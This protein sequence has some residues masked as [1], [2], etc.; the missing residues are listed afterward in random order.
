MAPRTRYFLV[1]S[2]LVIVIGL[3]TGLV[4]YYGGVTGRAAWRSDLAYVPSMAR[5]VGYADLSDIIG[6]PFHQH[7][8]RLL[9][10]G[11]DKTT[12]EHETGIDV[13]RDIDS[14]LVALGGDTAT[15]LGPL[16][17]VR[18]RFDQA[19]IEGTATA[20]GALAETYRDVRMLVAPADVNAGGRLTGVPT[21]AFLKS[22]LIALGSREAIRQALD[23]EASGGDVSQD[24]DLM[25]VVSRVERTGNAWFVVRTDALTAETQLPEVVRHHLDGV[26]FFAVGA[27]VDQ[28]LRALVRAEA[29]DARSAEDLRA[30]IAGAVAAVRMMSTRDPRLEAALASVQTSGSGP[31]VEVQFTLP[32]DLLDLAHER[33]SLPA[34]Q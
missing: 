31:A 10:S 14:V 7:L 3:C 5:A 28:N 23:A 27:D 12:F 11:S 17:V 15:D 20:R 29:R 9:P 1:G 25:A 2:G 21:V 4:A 30:V 33:G 22:G 8:Q 13:E 6:S 18:G 32:P 19:K 24:G 34:V 16:V 26:R